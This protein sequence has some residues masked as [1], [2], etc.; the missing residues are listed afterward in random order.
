MNHPYGIH[1]EDHLYH[2]ELSNLLEPKSQYSFDYTFQ[3]IDS[4]LVNYEKWEEIF[5]GPKPT[6]TLGLYRNRSARGI[7]GNQATFDNS[8]RNNLRS[9]LRGSFSRVHSVLS[10]LVSTGRNFP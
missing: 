5:D 8:Q 2:Q 7:K 10:S 9:G 3:S 1:F 4:E 6:V